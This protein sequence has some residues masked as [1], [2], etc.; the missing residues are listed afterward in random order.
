MQDRLGLIV[1]RVRGD[2]KACPDAPS[3]R[4][5]HGVPSTSRSGLDPL[6][7][8]A[9]RRIDGSR[10]NFAGQTQLPRKVFDE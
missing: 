1:G 7:S 5:Q 2:D 6:A 9:G 10:R 4:L 8:I 3:H